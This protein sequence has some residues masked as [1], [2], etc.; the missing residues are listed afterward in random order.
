M[1][2]SSA[3]FLLR[4]LRLLAEVESHPGHGFGGLRV[5]S[6]RPQGMIIL[7]VIL[8]IL[9]FVAA[10]PMLW[11]IGVILVV[12]GFVLWILGSMGHA[13]GGRRLYY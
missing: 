1:A 5:E 2:A 9:G 11:T 6:W 3:P 8:M 7:G 10:V 12:V 4:L 13:V